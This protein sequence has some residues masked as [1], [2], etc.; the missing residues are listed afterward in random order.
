MT[1][2]IVKGGAALLCGHCGRISHHPADVE[3]RYCAACKLFHQDQPKTDHDRLLE[4]LANALVTQQ[5]YVHSLLAEI[6]RRGATFDE[7]NDRFLKTVALPA[8]RDL[9]NAAYLVGEWLIQQR[10]GA[11]RNG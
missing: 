4:R 9:Y 2:I 3:H 8:G 10:E 11:Q 7:L 5:P 6:V 1:Y